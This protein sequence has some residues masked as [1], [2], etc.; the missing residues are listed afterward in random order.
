M[1]AGG[2]RQLLRPTRSPPS[3]VFPGWSMRL[4]KVYRF[5]AV[6]FSA[7]TTTPASIA[8]KPVPSSPSI[9][10][11]PSTWGELTTGTTWS[12]L[13]QV[14]TTTRADEPCLKLACPSSIIRRNLPVLP[15]THSPVTCKTTR[16]GETT[17]RVG[18][19]STPP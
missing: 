17:S 2:L 18:E 10:S 1:A 4:R 15:C 7:G 16:S 12:R 5:H 9:M 6:R 11:N 3:S 8:E 13:V 14:V 19:A